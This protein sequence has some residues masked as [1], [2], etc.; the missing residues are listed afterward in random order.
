MAAGVT[1]KLWSIEDI[2]NI[3]EAAAPKAGRPATYKKRQP[4]ILN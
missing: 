1:N 4:E 3:V 2:A